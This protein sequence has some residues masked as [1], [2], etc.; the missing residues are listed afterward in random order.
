MK[1]SLIAFTLIVSMIL[2]CG[3]GGCGKENEMPLNQTN[4]TIAKITDISIFSSEISGDHYLSKP[5]AEMVSLDDK[6]KF[7]NHECGGV[8]GEVINFYSK[9]ATLPGVVGGDWMTKSVVDC[10]SYY[11]VQ[12]FYDWGPSY[13]G[14]FDK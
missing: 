8:R 2:I 12:E 5:A 4:D 11:W 13:F 3:I 9:P 7:W 6:R 14:P 10:G 1:K